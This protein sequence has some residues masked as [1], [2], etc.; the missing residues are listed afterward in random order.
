MIRNACARTV[1]IR[2]SV[3]PVLLVVVVVVVAASSTSS[4]L[5]R[6]HSI[7]STTRSSSSTFLAHKNGPHFRTPCDNHLDTTSVPRKC[8]KSTARRQI[9]LAQELVDFVRGGGKV[10]EQDIQL[11]EYDDMFSDETTDEEDLSMEEEEPRFEK[12][13][14]EN[15]SDQKDD[16]DEVADNESTASTSSIDKTPFPITVKTAVG[17]NIVDTSLELT[18]NRSRDVASL[19]KSLSRLL[20]AKPPVETMKLIFHGK[21]LQDDETLDE[22]LDDDEDEED[23]EREAISLTLD[24]IPPVDPKFVAELDANLKDMTVREILD[25]YIANEA[26]LYQST[27]ELMKKTWSQS[28]AGAQAA[29]LDEEAD[30]DETSPSPKGGNQKTSLQI[31]ERSDQIRSQLEALIQSEN[32]KNLL[33][34][35]EIKHHSLDEVEV[36]GQRIRK[37]SQA[38]VRTSIKRQIQRNLNVNWPETIRYFVLFIFFGYFGGRTP[39]SR[40]VLLLGAPSVF[41]LQ[42][43]PVK[44]IA[45]QLFYALLDHPPSIFLSLLPA[46][47]QAILDMNY[48]NSM[49]ALYGDDIPETRGLEQEKVENDGNDDDDDFVDPTM[50]ELFDESAEFSDESGEESDES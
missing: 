27:E 50:E 31:R 33:S 44:L 16:Q 25:A 10:E 45:K 30:D 28:E 6:R 18:V 48:L 3:I 5:H 12:V 49:R 29:D 4:S 7:W 41:L 32:S 20:P 38:G 36:R 2:L 23:E 15:F 13:D 40:A 26:T 43:R 9:K 22:I 8:Q 14:E 37:V 46:P 21:V 1:G 17:N 24:M 19:K 39:F 34:Q 35:T 42:Y 47:Q 11:R